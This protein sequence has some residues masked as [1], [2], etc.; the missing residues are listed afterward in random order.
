MCFGQTA[1]CSWL[2]S[3][4]HATLIMKA[5]VEKESPLKRP[6]EQLLLCLQQRFAL[7]S[8]FSLMLATVTRQKGA[9]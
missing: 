4:T 8:S 7:D 6:E 3:D 5:R 2:Q 1:L 9:D